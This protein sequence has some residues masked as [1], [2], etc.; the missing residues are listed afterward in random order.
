M[1]AGPAGRTLWAAS[2][3]TLAA[4]H[5][6]AQELI[7][8]CDPSQTIARWTL[9]ATLHT[10][11]GDFK[12]KHGEIHWDPVSGE[13]SGKIVFDATSGQSGNSSRDSKMHRVVLDSRQYPEISFR[14]DHTAGQGNPG[15]VSTVE[16]HGTF[17]I[18]G[19]DHEI[20]VP[21]EVRLEADHWSAAAHFSV[22]YV[23]W[24]MKNPSTFLLHVADSVE[25]D[26]RAAGEVSRSP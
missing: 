18:H 25:I 1:T 13:T 23:A 14:P 5:A 21:V 9:D 7:L 20:A 16:V 19:S 22:P 15:G 12:L 26:M 10:V 17:A 4:A 3:L 24:G 8:R 6:V 11:S 2:L